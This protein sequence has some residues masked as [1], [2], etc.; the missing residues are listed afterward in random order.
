MSRE[1]TRKT[2]RLR[3]NNL[4]NGCSTDTVTLSL[5]EDSIFNGA[6]NA[7]QVHLNNN[8][9]KQDFL[10]RILMFGLEIL[11][12]RERELSQVAPS[13][14]LLLKFGAKWKYYGLVENGMTPYHLI[15]KSNGDHH[16]LL[17]LLLG[18]SK[19]PLMD[20]EDCSSYT[21]LIYAI[22][23][24]NINCVRSLLKSGANVNL[25]TCSSIISNNIQY[26][27]PI[28]SPLVEA[29]TKLDSDS[30][31]LTKIKV[32]IFHLLLAN[33]A[34]V[35]APCG[36]FTPPPVLC[37]LNCG[38]VE[39]M[40]KLI[41]QGAQLGMTSYERNHIWAEI[42]RKSNVEVLK[43]V[44]ERGINKDSTDKYG[45]SMLRLVIES[46]DVEA[47]RYLL[48]LGVTVTTYQ[49]EAQFIPCKKCGTIRLYLGTDHVQTERDPCMAAISRDD[50]DVFQLLEKHGAQGFGLFVVL[51]QA[52][53]SSPDVTEYL[54][55]KYTYPLNIEYRI[56]ILQI[57]PFH[58]IDYRTLLSDACLSNNADV[59]KMLLDHGADPNRR[60]CEEKCFSDPYTSAI[61]IAIHKCSVTIVAH[62]IR[63]GLNINSSSYHHRYG[64]VLPFEAAVLD[65]NIDAAKML[66]VAGCSCGVYS[67]TR[68]HKFKANVNPDLK[69]FMKNWNVASN[70]ATS[71]GQQCRRMILEHL[72]P[73]A[74]KK[75]KELPLPKRIIKYL[76]LPELDDMMDAD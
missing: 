45:K 33:G 20:K 21:A 36:R 70:N 3:L 23:K 50:L 39:C 52:T 16:E 27:V 68:G 69:S 5:F 41:Q 46:G 17:D 30:E 60:M 34:N 61:N 63:S 76:S 71:L 12:K 19:Q 53:Y 38:N 75:I 47:V 32:E 42:V 55:N 44:I 43:S 49:L 37:A 1:P 26:V 65:T 56:N 29:M 74:H 14:Q 58:K 7:F 25:Y 67:L 62:L 51:L 72:S 8:P 57:G 10:N 24:A 31:H 28:C 13:L 73:Q 54:L 15:C 59:V 22:R 2:S 11:Q 6:H 66:L 35:S 64:Y 18:S 9:I 48:E 40:K 4:S